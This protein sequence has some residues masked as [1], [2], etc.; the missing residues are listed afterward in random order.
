MFRGEL[1]K[2]P[3]KTQSAKAKG[4]RLQQVIVEA[5]RRVFS[6]GEDDVSSRSMSAPG[7]DVLLSSMARKFFPYSIE[8]KRVEKLNVWEA[9]RQAQANAPKGAE[10]IVV[11]QRNR[12]VPYVVVDMEVFLQLQRRATRYMPAPSELVAGDVHKTAGEE[13]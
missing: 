13:R 4:R 1:R 8:C 7:E 5:I 11:I 10:P 3:I 12:S 6:L 9:I 2:P